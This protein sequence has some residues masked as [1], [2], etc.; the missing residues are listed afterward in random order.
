MKS[1]FLRW[2]F[3]IAAAAGL[4]GA[5]Q[6]RAQTPAPTVVT[7]QI[8]DYEKGY[9][10][11]TTGDGFHVAPNVQIVDYKTQTA[12]STPPAT[13]EYA[14][15][16]FDSTGL[17]TKIEISKSKLAEQG[18]PSQVTRFAIALSTPA[19][20]PELVPSFGAPAECLNVTPGKRVNVRFTVQVPP[21]TTL[22]DGVYMTTDQSAWN[23]LAYKFDRVDALHYRA[24]LSLLSG[25][26]FSFLFDRGSSQSLERGENGIEA[27][28]E[29]FCVG[30]A[31]VQTHTHTVY[32][33]GDETGT[34]S[35]TV[36]QALPTPYNPAPF[37][38]LPTPPP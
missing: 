30:S 1:L 36:P 33:W 38:N 35:L 25:T 28:P 9:L 2:T 7:A 19:P 11:F 27:K 22:Q 12:L 15:V 4:I 23:P 21:S 29:H 13:R 14:R 8:L 6:A 5:S 32:H 17:V 18:D 34:N 10:F 16:T 3:A 31:D 26:L 20:N 37:P 24:T